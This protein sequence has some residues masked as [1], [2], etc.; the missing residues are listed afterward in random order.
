MAGYAI[1]LTTKLKNEIS[2]S[3]DAVGLMILF[4]WLKILMIATSAVFFI[5]A[6][7]NLLLI[8]KNKVRL[9]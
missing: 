3:S 2:Y 9:R 8:P 1:L 6:F 4:D 7:I 5:T